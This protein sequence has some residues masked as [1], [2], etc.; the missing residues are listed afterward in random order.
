M[1]ENEKEV[2]DAK[3]REFCI[4]NGLPDVKLTW[5]N[6]P[7]SGEW[8]IAA[9]LFPLAAA[10]D[11]T[12]IETPVAQRAQELAER[13]AEYIGMPGGIK[14]VQAVKGYLNLYFSSAI[15]AQKVTEQVIDQGDAYGKGKPTGQVT[16]V[17]YSQPN[18]H[19][20][21]HVGHLRN[22]ILGGSVSNILEAAGDQVVRAN[23]IG[24][25]GLH[26]IKWMWNYVK[27]HQ[28][29]E[30][31]EDKT[32]WMGELYA[33]ADRRFSDEPD[34]EA[35]VRQY[36]IRWDNQDPELV[37]LWQ[38]TR[39]WS[40]EGFY[41]VYDLL[42]EHF[43]RIY[44]E[45]EV[46]ETGKAFVA[47][48][49]RNGQATDGRP[50][51][52]V[53]VN[54]DEWLGTK[55]EYRVAVVLRSDGTS[56]YAT[57]ELPLAVLK[58]DEY[59]LDRSIYVI[60]VRQ[61]LHLKQIFKILE[62]L[63]YEWATRM[64]HL[65]YEIVNLPGNVTMSSRD[66]T[67]VLLNDL[68]R[69][70]TQRALEIVNEKNPELSEVRKLAI[71]SSVAIGAI[72]YPMLSRENTKVVTFDWE[73]AMDF[74]GQS[75]PYIQYAHVRAGS[76]LRKTGQDHPT[77]FAFQENLEDTEINLLEIISKLPGEVQ[78][79][80]KELKPSL[81]ANYAYELAKAFND[82]YNTCPV[83]SASEEKKN[84]RLALV[85]AAK[86]CLKN[87]LGLLGIKAPEVM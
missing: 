84:Y 33:E 11:R 49:I 44:F 48:M 68:I 80:A 36:F 59:H 82:F 51:N 19:K 65:A 62:I 23:Y 79:A 57:K 72:K 77:G 4:K 61:S 13:L 50:D 39:L 22:V 76:I 21:L 31:G 74:N 40:L 29:E 6:I 18:T 56:L 46:E 67:V 35:E 37:A 87:S 64:V 66:G 34:F 69:E 52:P 42:G 53:F 2:I 58:F 1:F 43:D 15:Q 10:E 73:S 83:L 14:R 78:K 85:G 28:G 3:V 41:Q 45:S 54:L 30:P 16:M 8:G 55:E 38:K 12:N 5:R 20:D 25:I 60:D 27:H 63:G 32:R 86:Q 7:F 26:V 24:D 17:E 9:P 71:A 81:I 47:D 75:A 70:A